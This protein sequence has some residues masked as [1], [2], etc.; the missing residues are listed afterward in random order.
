LPVPERSAAAG[1]PAFIG[2]YRLWISRAKNVADEQARG[3]DAR[4]TGK[5]TGIVRARDVLTRRVV[6]PTM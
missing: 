2:F 5:F 1:Y 4:K 6:G 3:A